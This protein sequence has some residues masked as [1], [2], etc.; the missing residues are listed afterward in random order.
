MTFAVS[1]EVSG[2]AA[3]YYRTVGASSWTKSS[4]TVTITDGVGKL[5]VKPSGNREYRIKFG[6]AY[7]E[8][9]QF[10]RSYPVITASPDTSEG[11]LD[12]VR[13]TY[14]ELTFTANTEAS[15]KASLYYRTN[16]GSWRKSSTTVAMVDGV[17]T[18]RVKPSGDRDYRIKFGGA[19]SSMVEF[20]QI[21]P[22]VTATPNTDVE[23]AE[24][25]PGMYQT[26]TFEVDPALTGTAYLY[27]RTNGGS[28]KKSST[29]IK[30]VNGE[31]SKNVKPSGN[32][33]YKIRFGGGESNVVS[34]API[35]PA[36]GL[37]AAAG[38]SYAP[39]ESQTLSISVD[40]AL[41][42]T[43]Y[44]YYRKQGSSTWTKASGSITVTDGEATKI[45]NPQGS[46]GYRIKFG[47]TYS[48]A[49]LFTPAEG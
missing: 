42:G 40:P 28:W 38:T 2:K 48:D 30:I 41:S 16:G 32:R 45:V 5:K 29:T 20:N 31:G 3:V 33:E 10:T 19:Y 8:P 13:G 22:T 4:A 6:G 46:R 23:P 25:V 27:Y 35:V 34:F 15:G 14:H 24:Y 47:S 1:P 17:G 26:L 12:Y 21:P 43:A 44:L 36:V 11:E 9:V 49:L 39:G 7:S 18:I 37:T